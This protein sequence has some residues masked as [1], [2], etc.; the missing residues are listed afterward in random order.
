MTEVLIEHSADR[1]WWLGYLDTGV[2]DVV[3]PDAPT[4]PL[5]A[6]GWR[7]VLVAAGPQQAIQW[8]QRD[9]WEGVLPDLIFPA[10][11]SWLVSTLWDDTLP[12]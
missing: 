6:G 8:R 4:V 11:R 7:Y 5:Y 9:P 2:A 12:R 1:S 10:D 3:F